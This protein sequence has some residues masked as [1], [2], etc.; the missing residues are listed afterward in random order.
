MS[1][2]ESSLYS[3]LLEVISVLK[4]IIFGYLWNVFLYLLSKFF[5]RGVERGFKGKPYP[6]L[7][8]MVFSATLTQDPGKL[9]QLDPHHP[10][11]LTTGKMRYQLP[12][13]LECYKLVSHHFLSINVTLLRLILVLYE[14]LKNYWSKLVKISWCMI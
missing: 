10:L 12:E 11:L 6:R 4:V 8:K 3:N 14:I 7:V 9:A 2:L 5:C 13:K 1:I